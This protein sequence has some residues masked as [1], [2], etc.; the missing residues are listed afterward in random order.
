M[1]H[2]PPFYGNVYIGTPW[3]L[4]HPGVITVNKD[5][6]V[7]CLVST[8]PLFVLVLVG[9]CFILVSLCVDVVSCIVVLL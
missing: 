5:P 2:A 4:F 7:F 9:L 1:I 8:I 6:I 3:V